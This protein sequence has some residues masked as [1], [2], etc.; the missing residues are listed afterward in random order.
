M[1]LADSSLHQPPARRGGLSLVA[2]ALIAAALS[3]LSLVYFYR[4]GATNWYGDG[5]AHVNIARKVVDHPDDSL[6]QR[7]IQIGSPWLP[8]QTALMLPLVRDDTLWRTGLA[9]SIVSMVSFVIAAL[10]LYLNARR[11]YSREAERL[12][13]ALPALSV[14]CFVL[15]PSALY[16]QSTPMSE[17]VFMA[18]LA[19]SVWVFHRWAENQTT[20]KLAMAA[21]AMSVATLSRYEAWAVAATAILLVPL[22]SRGGFTSRLR[23]ALTFAPLA[24][25]GPV[26]WL[27]HNWAIYGNAIE[28]LTGTY[29]ARGV[30][31]GESSLGWSKIFS[32]NAAADLLLMLGAVSVCAGPVL[33]M[34]AVAGSVRVIASRRSLIVIAPALLLC[35]PFVFHVLSLYRGEIQLFPLSAFGLLNVRYGL[36]HLLPI[37]LFAPGVVLLA[38]RVGRTIAVVGFCLLLTG[39]Y[40]YLLSEGASQLAIYQ[41]AYRNGVNSQPARERARFAELLAGD[42]PRPTIL[43][44]TGALGPLVARG[45]WRFADTIH[46][47]T[48]RWHR[49]GNGI[50]ADVETVIIQAGDPLDRLIKERPELARDL[51]TD[52]RESLAMGRIK[53]FR[54]LTQ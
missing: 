17:M 10:A 46:E 31:Q 23:A 5:V 35:V 44:H 12:R 13:S 15:N 20:R 47:G 40:A 11:L 4:Q 39:Q 19:C 33:L 18:A 2:V 1:P 28:F 41:E 27:W 30:S 43:M 52:F 7:Y 3:V 51:A 29:S 50:P 21:L 38:G 24:L 6:W 48:M 36:L 42:P 54:R 37:A 34:L 16:M 14:A 49:L 8:L 22:V 45:G 9:G 32:G 25:I 53:L 26:Y